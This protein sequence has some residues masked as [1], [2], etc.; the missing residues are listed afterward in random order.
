[1]GRGRN[2]IFA[3]FV[4]WVLTIA[5]ACNPKWVA[6]QSD[7][8]YL[9][10]NQIKGDSLAEA[11]LK[12]YSDS[13]SKSMGRVLCHSAKALPKI[14]G[15]AETA[16]GNLMSDIVLDRARK[17]QPEVQASLLNLGGLR[18][19]LPEGP[20]TL[21]NVFSLMPFD[22]RI[23]LV[24]LGPKEK[25]EM[26]RYIGEHPGTPFSGFE[27][28]CENQNWMGFLKG[29]P[30]PEN[31]SFYV[32]TSDFLAQGGDKMNFFLTN[33]LFFDP[34]VLLRDA[35]ISYMVESQQAGKNIHSQL[36]NRI[37]PCTE[38]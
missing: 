16:L 24:K 5:L 23:A 14:K 18:A 6:V 15:S 3:L 33:P 2:A 21:G 17:N 19:S 12:P 10:L 34:G 28:R 38:K 1:M 27:L 31:D 25:K 37:V 35:I 8:S 22:N 36:D 11:L 20:I 7:A 26:F 9:S 32:A 13:V 30:I 29:E 4:F